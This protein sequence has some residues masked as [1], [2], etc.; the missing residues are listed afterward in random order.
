MPEKLLSIKEVADDLKISEEE[1]K[2]L[3]DSGERIRPAHVLIA[4]GSSP[5]RGHA[6][7]GIEHVIS[8]NEVF[9]LAEFPR[10][11]LVQGGSYIAVEFACIFAG[12]G[13]AVSLVYRGDNILRGFD[14]DLRDRLRASP[15]GDPAA[16][17]VRFGDALHELWSRW[18]FGRD[19]APAAEAPRP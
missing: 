19:D 2:R 7:P 11:V 15:L 6:I 10:R 3:V 12:L 18:A 5:S 14:D 4:T 1:V 17:A 9:S 8:S 16:Y 13:A